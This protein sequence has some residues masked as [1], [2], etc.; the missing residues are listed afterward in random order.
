MDARPSINVVNKPFFLDCVGWSEDNNLVVCLENNIYL[1]TPILVSVSSDVDPYDHVSLEPVEEAKDDFDEMSVVDRPLQPAYALP[2]SY[3]CAVWSPTGLTSTQGCFLTVVTT[4]HRV[5]LYNRAEKDPKMDWTL[6]IDMTSMIRKI[7]L[8]GARKFSTVHEIDRFQTLY[9]AWS[10]RIIGDS[11]AEKPALLALSN[12]VGEINIWSFAKHKGI[13]HGIT[14]Q[15]HRSFVNLLR[16]TDWHKNN[17]QYTAYLLSTCSDGTVALS[18]VTVTIAIKEQETRVSSVKAKTLKTWFEHDNVV[19]TLVRTWD[20]FSHSQTIK[21]VVAKSIT[22]YAATIQ[23]NGDKVTMQDEW[24]NYPLQYS[25]MGLSGANWSLDGEFMRVYTFEGECVVL[26]LRGGQLVYLEDDS[27]MVNRKLL[28]KYNQQWTEEQTD[29]EEGNLFPPSEVMPILW[30]TAVSSRELYTAIL[31]S[32]RPNADVTYRGET[33]MQTSLA[34][35]MH[36]EPNSESTL[37][38][39]SESIN[40]LIQKPEF[41]FTQS[42]QSLL[43]EHLEYLTKDDDPKSIISWLSVF[44]RIM[45]QDVTQNS[46]QQ[47]LHERLYD[48]MQ[49]CAARMLLY[50]HFALK[51]YELPIEAAT[52]LK[53]ICDKAQ[54]L[55]WG[56]YLTAILQYLLDMS[57]AEFQSYH[58]D[59]IMVMLLLCDRALRQIDAPRHLVELSKDVYERIGR[60]FPSSSVYTSLDT[61]L[62]RAMALLGGKET[63][64]FA[65]VPREKCPVCEE[66]ISPSDQSLAICQAGHF[67]EQCSMTLR[68]LATPNIRKCATCGAKS[69]KPELYPS[70]E[71]VLSAEWVS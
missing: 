9:A 51:F 49:A 65:L 25:A 17:H 22:V 21:L 36:A 67:W 52:Y 34:F 10:S 13:R 29:I 26:T 42:I 15:P 71:N 58:D 5:F 41:L 33:T 63:T 68:V 24:T 60:V 69:L 1:L 27:S 8:D 4:K 56:N 2:E 14:L 19:P 50:I 32:L 64:L 53:N 28:Q 46:K 45:E 57:D 40:Q 23:V 54:K 44:E 12:K 66:L 39:L 55:A 37:N 11:L 18:S 59:D 16:W 43:Y 48:N 7:A 6:A 62:D 35:I 30:G 38:S 31:F 47:S 20:D 61:E 3:R 70:A